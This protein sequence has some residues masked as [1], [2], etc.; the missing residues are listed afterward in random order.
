[1]KS[2]YHFSLYFKVYANQFDAYQALGY[3]SAKNVLE[4]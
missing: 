2:I 4:G 3:N 1:M